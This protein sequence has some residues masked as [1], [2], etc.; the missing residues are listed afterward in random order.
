MSI[1][2]KNVPT[3]DTQTLESISSD[4]FFLIKVCDSFPKE[5]PQRNAAIEVAIAKGSALSTAHI[6]KSLS[7]CVGVMDLFKIAQA[8]EGIGKDS[9]T[10]PPLSLIEQVSTEYQTVH[11]AIQADKEPH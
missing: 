11:L 3:P 8:I 9:C 6:L 7:S 4:S 5:A 2:P 1:N 10:R